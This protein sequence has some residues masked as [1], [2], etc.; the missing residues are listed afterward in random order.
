MK[1]GNFYPPDL[2]AGFVDAPARAV[3]D[4]GPIVPRTRAVYTLEG[5]L[6][7]TMRRVAPTILLNY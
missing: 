5:A 1:R 7:H 4:R 2:S 3:E 6:A